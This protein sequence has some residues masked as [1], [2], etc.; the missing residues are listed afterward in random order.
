MLRAADDAWPAVPD[1]DWDRAFTR[2]NGWTGGDA[3]Y[4]LDI[5]AGRALWLFA[6]TW[7][8]KVEHGRHVDARLV[9]NTL[10]MHALPVAGQPPRPDTLRFRW[11]SEPGVAPPKAWIWPATQSGDIAHDSEWYWVADAILAPSATGTP[12]LLI[13]LWRIERNP[14]HGV[15]SFRSAGGNLAVVDNPQDD[16]DRWTI[17]QLEIPHAIGDRAAKESGKRSLSWGSEVLLMNSGANESDLYI[18]GTRESG[19]VVLA[20]VAATK[21]TDFE[22]W[23]FRTAGG[24]SSDLNQASAIAANVTT[25]FSVNPIERDGHTQWVMIHSEPLFGPHVMLRVA[26]VPEGP[27]SKPRPI[28]RV[29]E[30][31]RNKDYFTYAAKAHP[32]LSRPSELLI[33]YVVNSFDFA[34]G[35]ADAEIYRPRFI[36]LP[37]SAIP[38]VGANE[39]ALR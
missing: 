37:H 33:T 11:G 13:F 30:L 4:S 20:R 12:R 6:D 35:V 22:S 38:A 27:W 15:F 17:R 24:W 36:R 21:A 34:A 18:Y 31:A 32:E 1:A 25:E 8:G 39:S 29:P 19:Q 10:A 3:M 7:I 14:G 26:P 23:Q 28:F 5:G 9:N 16:W 2:T